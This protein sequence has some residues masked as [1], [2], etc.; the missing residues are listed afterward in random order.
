VRDEKDDDNE[1]KEPKLGKRAL[2]TQAK[3]ARLEAESKV[4]QK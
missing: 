3:K 2:K 1:D 4:D